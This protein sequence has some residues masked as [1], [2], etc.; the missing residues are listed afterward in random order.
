MHVKLQKVWRPKVDL[1]IVEFLPFNFRNL[2]LIHMKVKSR[3][4]YDSS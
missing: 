4:F 2:V 1:A 3:G